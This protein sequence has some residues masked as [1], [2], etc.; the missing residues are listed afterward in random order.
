MHS[1]R[2]KQKIS[3]MVT[4]KTVVQST[5]ERKPENHGC[6]IVFPVAMN[7]LE[8]TAGKRI[9]SFTLRVFTARG[10]R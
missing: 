8:N 9:F 10:I 1:T 2:G 3:K 4:K 7:M 6:F 5:L